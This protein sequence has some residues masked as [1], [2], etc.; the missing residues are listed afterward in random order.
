MK[1]ACIMLSAI[2]L[3]FIVAGPTPAAEVK[4]Q[5]S[6]PGVVDATTVRAGQ[7]FTV[8][9][10]F[11]ND[12]IRTGFTMGFSLKSSDLKTVVHVADTAGGL[13]ELGDIKGH[14]GWQDKSVW[15]LGGIYAVERDWDGDL[16]E[17]IGFGGVCIKKRYTAHDW[18]KQLSFDLMIPETGTLVIDSSFYPPGGKW[19]FSSPQRIAPPEAPKWHGP[20]TI[21]VI[22]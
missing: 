18:A 6:G 4:M 9:I 2:C 22:K 12:T 8:E 13:N 19:L 17:L 15:D 10:M 21:K 11:V 5:L 1:T 20:Y 14:N 3:M 16:P 7:P